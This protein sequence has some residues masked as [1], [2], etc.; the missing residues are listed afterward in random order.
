M[1]VNQG[2]Y[3]TIVIHTIPGNQKKQQVQTFSTYFSFLISI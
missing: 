2:A 1:L 3:K